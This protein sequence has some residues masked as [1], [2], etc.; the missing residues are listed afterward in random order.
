[1]PNSSANRS[2]DPW[3]RDPTATATP[4]S[5]S[6][7]SVTNVLAIPPV[8]RIPQR[9]G[10][11]ATSSSL[12]RSVSATSLLK[13]GVRSWYGGRRA[14]PP[15]PGQGPAGPRVRAAAGRPGDGACRADVA[16]A[17]LP[18]VP[19]R[20]RRYTVWLLAGQ[21]RGTGDGAVAQ[22]PHVRDGRVPGR[23][24]HLAWLVQLDVYAPR[25]RAAV[26]LQGARP[27]TA[28]PGPAVHDARLGPSEVGRATMQDWRSVPGRPPVGSGTWHFPSRTR[29][30]SAPTW[31]RH[32]PSTPSGSAS[33]S[34]TTSRWDRRC[35]GS[36]STPPATPTTCCWPP[37]IITSRRPTGRRCAR[38]SPR[39][40]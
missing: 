9:T 13:G 39:A 32:S 22:R 3:L 7:R 29:P 15:A 1:M 33:R 36:P 23:G 10:M 2:A 34:T 21:A 40:T 37:S 14:G 26:C 17:V 24:V 16:V 38:S 5:V 11:S 19:P 28:D 12:R 20:L 27:L 6:R 30:C 35:A 8:P 31:T 18:P 4:E 25:R